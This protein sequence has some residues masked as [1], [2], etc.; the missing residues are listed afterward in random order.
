MDRGV[1]KD[2]LKTLQLP[3]DERSVGCRLRQYK[4]ISR[5]WPGLTLP[6]GHAYETSEALSAFRLVQTRS[7]ASRTKMIAI[8]FR[9]KLRPRLIRYRVTE[10]RLLSLELAG[11]VLRVDPVQYVFLLI[12]GLYEVLD[13]RHTLPEAT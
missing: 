13:S 9:R 12:W 11:F 4:L 5:P 10:H 8:L 2:I 7:L 6:H 1:W 3:Y